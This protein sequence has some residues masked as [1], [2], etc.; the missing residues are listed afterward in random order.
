MKKPSN[1]PWRCQALLGPNR[2]FPLFCLFRENWRS[3]STVLLI[4]CRDLEDPIFI[5]GKI[6]SSLLTME[7]ND[8]FFY[9]GILTV[10]YKPRFMHCVLLTAFRSPRTEGW[11]FSKGH[12][13]GYL[14]W[15]NVSK[16]FWS[17]RLMFCNAY[18]GYYSRV[19]WIRARQS[20]SE[21]LSNPRQILPME[22]RVQARTAEAPRSSPGFSFACS[23]ISCVWITETSCKSESSFQQ[24]GI[25]HS[26]NS[27]MSL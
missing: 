24:Y 14:L 10:L 12:C 7:G 27:W 25:K 18:K 17:K 21:R 22:T 16:M 1:H 15:P 3:K 4:F 9:H 6:C 8:F 2:D 23:Y 26:K 20:W 19:Q 5:I 13:I 11:T